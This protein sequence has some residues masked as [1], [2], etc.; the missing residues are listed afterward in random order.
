[1]A[2]MAAALSV[3]SCDRPGKLAGSTGAVPD[4]MPFSPGLPQRRAVAAPLALFWTDSTDTTTT[5]RQRGIYA[6][7]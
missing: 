6:Q 5:N 7:T 3:S 4:G 2:E 1:M